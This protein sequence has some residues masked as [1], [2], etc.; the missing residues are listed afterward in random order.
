MHG[1]TSYFN[2]NGSFEWSKHFRICIRCYNTTVVF[3]LF[4]VFVR[5]RSIQTTELFY[6][7]N[8][9]SFFILLF[10]FFENLIA[11]NIPTYLQ[12]IKNISHV[13]PEWK[14]VLI[15]A[16]VAPKINECIEMVGTKCYQKFWMVMIMNSVFRARGEF[17][18]LRIY[19]F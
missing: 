6:G 18:L 12:N 10:C 5:I 9:E 13:E 16:A 8:I 17:F 4:L 11:N 2:S 7:R 14:H 3:L 15:F 1:V 19:L